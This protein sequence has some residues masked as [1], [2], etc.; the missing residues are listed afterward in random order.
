MVGIY[1]DAGFLKYK[2]GVYTGCPS[3]AASLIN[4]AVMLYGWDSNGNWLIKNQYGTSWGMSG[5]MVLSNTYDCGITSD[6][7]LIKIASPNS[8][9][10][11]IMDPTS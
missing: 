7:G 11:V 5:F 4:H 6:I 10:A 3:N 2:S 1:A 9:P 8:N